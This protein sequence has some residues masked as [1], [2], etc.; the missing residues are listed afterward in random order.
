[1]DRFPSLADQ[2]AANYYVYHRRK[3]HLLDK[4]VEFRRLFDEKVKDSEI[5]LQEVGAANVYENPFLKYQD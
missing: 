5:L 4:Y 1:M 3:G 2:N